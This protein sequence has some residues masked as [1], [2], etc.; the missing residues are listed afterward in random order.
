[1]LVQ[2]GLP[3]IIYIRI[4]I[5]SFF[6]FIT[7]NYEMKWYNLDNQG[8]IVENGYIIRPLLKIPAIYVYRLKTLNESYIGASIDLNRRFMQHRYRANKNLTKRLYNTLFYNAVALY[9]WE[10]FEFKVIKY[11]NIENTNLISKEEKKLLFQLEEDYIK[12]YSPSFNICNNTSSKWKNNL[13]FTQLNIKK[14]FKNESNLSIHPPIK[15]ETIIKLKM[16]KNIYLNIFNKDNEFIIQFDKIRQAADYIGVSHTTVS[17][18][19]NS[20]RLWNN[21]YYFKIN[22]RE[23]VK[24]L[25]LH[26]PLDSDVFKT[27][28][29]IKPIT[30]KRSYC[31]EVLVNERLIYQFKSLKEASIYLNIGR[32]ALSRYAKKGKLWKNKFLFKIIY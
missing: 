25:N 4:I 9:G 16:H 7:I 13:E 29:R 28:E 26:F 1:M 30:N 14:H 22:V 15:N 21:Q 10:N 24:P 27:I 17:D 5:D 6:I 11:L 12:K 23:N 2:V 31:L 19:A 20:G 32:K 18:Y 8:Y 3:I